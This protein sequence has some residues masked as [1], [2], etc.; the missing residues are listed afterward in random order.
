LFVRKK[1][2]E[3]LTMGNVSATL[4]MWAQWH[5]WMESL[6]SDARIFHVKFLTETSGLGPSPLNWALLI[7]MMHILF[8]SFRPTD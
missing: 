1:R 3:H 5:N 4:K 7:H 8:F 6:I 2:Q